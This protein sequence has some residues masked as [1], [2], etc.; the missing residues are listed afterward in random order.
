[1]NGKEEHT[2][3]IFCPCGQKSMCSKCF[4]HP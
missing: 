1:M 2:D 3:A 4:F